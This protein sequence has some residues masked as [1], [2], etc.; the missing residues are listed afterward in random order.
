MG[1]FST[2]RINQLGGNQ[3]ANDQVSFEITRLKNSD[4]Q[5]VIKPDADGCYSMV[6][7]AIDAHN[8]SGDFYDGPSM[9]KFFSDS[10]SFMRRMARGSL[11]AEWGHP[12]QTELDK[13]GHVI[14]NNQDFLRRVLDIYEKN[15]CGTWVK[16]WLGDEKVPDDKG[17]MV[18]PI[19]GKI[20]PSGPYGDALK[21][22]FETPG[23]NVNFSI[24]SLT[25]DVPMGG[26]HSKKYAQAII[27]FDYVNEPGMYVADKLLSPSLESLEGYVVEKYQ[28]SR[29]FVYDTIFGKDHTANLGFESSD[30]YHDLKDMLE[31]ND[32]EATGLK[33]KHVGNKQINIATEAFGDKV[34]PNLPPSNQW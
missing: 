16:I 6:I 31:Y 25:R 22:Q 23:E 14:A 20:R 8:S 34:K 32:A 10:S 13:D 33:I 7:G 27:T 19:W 2:Q 11:R 4:K 28:A 17:I 29:D 9:M 26:Y 21:K 5:G 12:R 1:I 3:M 24:R 30:I 18:T 15:V